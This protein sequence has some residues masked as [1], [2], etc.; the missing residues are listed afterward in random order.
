MTKK[1]RLG[2]ILDICIALVFSGEETIDSALSRYPEYADEIRPELEAAIW[3]NQQRQTT[4]AR[5]GYVNASRKRLVDQLKHE[6]SN[7]VPVKKPRLTWDPAIFGL[8]FVTLFLFVSVLAFRGGLQI[9]NASIPGDRFYDLKLAVED[10]QLS[11]A[12]DEVE[13]AELR[14]QFA[15]E[16][17]GEIEALIEQERYDDVQPALVNYRNQLTLAR[18]IITNL[19][20]DPVRKAELAQS[21]GSTAAEH[22]MVFSTFAAAEIPSG[23]ALAFADVVVFNNDLVTVMV[24]VLDDLGKVFVLPPG[25]TLEP[26]ATVFVP[27]NTSRPTDT[28]TPTQTPV[29]TSTPSP[30]PTLLPSATATATI[31][32]S[33]P[34]PTATL[35]PRAPAPT[36]KSII[37]T[38]K[39]DNE[40][41]PTNEPKPTKEPRPTKEPKPTKDKDKG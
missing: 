12:S 13:E 11:M 23:L 7:P 28:A 33:L 31:D 32:P 38:P 9:V 37:P 1:Q 6:T 15:D 4:A 10:T 25:V 3:L 18:D 30:S 41:E 20:G 5:P 24:V 34:T 40:P 14:I 29:P 22:S 39:E 35:D 8:V 16:R 27:T 19:E 21:L 26:T 17:A 2:D 36:E